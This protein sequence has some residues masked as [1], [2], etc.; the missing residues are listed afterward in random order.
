VQTSSFKIAAKHPRAVAISVGVPRWFRGRRFEA[1][2]PTRDMLK[3]PPGE[4]D[5]RFAEILSK[6]DPQKV[7]DELGEDAILLCW[8]KP[9]DP[10]HRRTV[11]AWFE[12]H[13]GKEVPELDPAT[14]DKGMDNLFGNDHK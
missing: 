14:F 2:A 3:M 6:L 5:L 9:G 4:Y 12:E 8:E 10:C 1:L 13:L 7:W 11:A